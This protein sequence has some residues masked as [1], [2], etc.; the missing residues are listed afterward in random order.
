MINILKKSFNGQVFSYPLKSYEGY[1]FLYTLRKKL[2]LFEEK[3]IALPSTHD[4]FIKIKSEAK[5]IKRT[6]TLILEVITQYLWGSQSGASKQFEKLITSSHLEDLI[7]SCSEE[8]SAHTITNRLFRIR[9]TENELP[10]RDQLFHIPFRARHLVA[11]QRYSI[12]G[13]PSLYLGSSI[14][15]C[16]LELGKPKFSNICISGYKPIGQISIL[17]LAYDLPQL[18]DELENHQ[19]SHEDFINKLMLWP[20][21][22]ACSFQI[23]YAYAAFHEE[24]ILPS[25]L[26]DWITF[27][28]KDI[29]GLKYLSTKLKSPEKKNYGINYVFPPQRLDEKFDYCKVLSNSFVLTNPLS[30]ELLTLLPPSDVVAKGACINADNLEDALLNNYEN[31]R[32]GFVEE[33]VFA[34]TFEKIKNN[35][36]N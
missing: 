34:M 4:I 7:L 33:Q 11:N 2:F 17:N 22:M 13:L 9:Q 12:A 1:G 29:H 18:I 3:I 19:I 31:S 28:G 26:L 5:Q 20:F 6:N 36:L 16:W 30:W 32:F 25:M 10:N 23:K 24:Y 27:H 21:L 15:V 35:A 14:Y 8:L